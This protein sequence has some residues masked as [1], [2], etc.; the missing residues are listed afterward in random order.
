MS[1]T[2]KQCCCGCSLK[3][4]TIIIGVICVVGAV[5]GLIYSIVKTSL[6]QLMTPE[7]AR[8]Q[9]ITED[10]R[11]VY[12]L[13][14]KAEKYTNIVAAVFEAIG[15]ILSV[16]LIFATRR[17][18]PRLMKPWLICSIITMV[19]VEV[20]Y[21][22]IMIIF[23]LYVS[24]GAGVTVLFAAATYGVVGAYMII[25]VDSHRRELLDQRRPGKM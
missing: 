8:Q 19:L 10:G 11:E 16:L 6:F 25:V 1:P 7:M 15:L 4:G 17:E 14:M 2:V 21:L 5:F 12:N 9:N 3:T 13:V 20:L 18:N 23:F 22:V 24:L